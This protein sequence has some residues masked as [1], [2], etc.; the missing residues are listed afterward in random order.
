[1]SIKKKVDQQQLQAKRMARRRRVMA[2]SELVKKRSCQL[3][4][5]SPCRKRLR[6]RTL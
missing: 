1:L 6:K 2:R 4:L 3:K 5:P